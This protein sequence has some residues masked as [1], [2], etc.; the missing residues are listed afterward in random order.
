MSTT[1]GIAFAAALLLILFSASFDATRGARGDTA[2]PPSDV[3][4]LANPTHTA[5]EAPP[6]SRDTGD[7][8][9]SN[10]KSRLTEESGEAV[11]CPDP[12]NGLPAAVRVPPI[13]P[14]TRVS[15]P[16]TGADEER[17]VVVVPGGTGPPGW[18]VQ[19]A[20]G[21]RLHYGKNRT[22]PGTCTCSGGGVSA[23]ATV[24]VG[25]ASVP[26]PPPSL[27]QHGGGAA[28]GDT[29]NGRGVV[30]VRRPAYLL[31]WSTVLSIV[32]VGG[33]GVASV[34]RAGG[35]LGP[36]SARASSHRRCWLHVRSAMV[37]LAVVSSAGG[38]GVSAAECTASTCCNVVIPTLDPLKL[39]KIVSFSGQCSASELAAGTCGFCNQGK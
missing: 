27:S 8:S 17:R 32:S 29:E 22:G 28:A 36:H 14:H 38:A 34:L 2:R 20:T 9:E 21:R 39:T 11:A 10:A 16:G 30:V 24:K 33:V 35:G 1:R 13:A 19:V 4:A 37:G 15:S 18:D 31:F 23:G 25:T 6:P 3:P 5:G 26:A 12:A 7:E